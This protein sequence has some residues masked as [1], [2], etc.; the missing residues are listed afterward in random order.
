MS[1]KL[2]SIVLLSWN[3]RHYTIPTLECLIKKTT[4]PHEFI[5]VDNGSVDGTREYLKDMEHNTNA[6]KVTYVFNKKNLGVAGGRNSG[7]VKAS[8]E[9][10]L[11]I[12]DD[13]LVPDE[14]DISIAD[15]CDNIPKLGIT[16]VNVEPFKLPV[17]EFNGVCVRPKAGNL[18]GACLCLPRRVFKRVGYYDVFGQ[19][20]HEDAMMYYRL[21]HLGLM[22]AY[23]E[24]RGVHMDTDD[25]KKYRVAKNKA[26]EKSSPP[27]RALASAR[28]RLIK[29]GKFY[30]PYVPYDPD[31]QPEE[32]LKF[33]N[34]MILDGRDKKE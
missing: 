18:G 7:L 34:D 30:V 13:I 20:G 9:Y 6:E 5:F 10:L 15:A 22:S 16:G 19:Y 8:G 25:D 32:L 29:T 17:K 24:R 2:M 26:H 21:K 27:L 23:I 1:N 33:D 28:M 12:D 4:I 3:R 31:K 11:T 14:W